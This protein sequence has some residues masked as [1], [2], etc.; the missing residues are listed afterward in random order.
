MNYTPSPEEDKKLHLRP[1]FKS[2]AERIAI[3]LNT[4]EQSKDAAERAG[5][6]N[7]LRDAFRLITGW[8]LV[9]HRRAWRVRIS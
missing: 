4:L 5:A 7:D 3:A 1:V 6:E 9:R 2:D 8:T